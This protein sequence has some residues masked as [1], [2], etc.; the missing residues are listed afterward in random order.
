MNLLSKF[1]PRTSPTSIVTLAPGEVYILRN[2]KTPKGRHECIFPEAELTLAKTSQE[3]CYELVVRRINEEVTET[4]SL[5]GEEDD[6]RTF[7]VDE[8]IQIGYYG[9][10][11]RPIIS[12][13]DLSGDDGDRYEFVCSSSISVESLDTFYD[14]ASVAQYERKYRQVP[15]KNADFKEFE[16][17]YSSEANSS[18]NVEGSKSDSIKDSGKPAVQGIGSLDTVTNQDASRMPCSEG[19]VIASENAT[20]CLFDSTKEIFIPQFED[21]TAVVLDQGNYE[22]WL[23]FRNSTFACLGTSILDELNPYSHPGQRALIFNYVT[24]KGLMLSYLAQ[25][26][27]VESLNRFENGVAIAEWERINRRHWQDLGEVD[28]EYVTNAMNNATIEDNAESASDEEDSSAESEEDDVATSESLAFAQPIEGTAS[29]NARNSALEVGHTN[30][31]TYVVRGNRI[32]VFKQDDQNLQYQ[33]TIDNVRTF[34]GKE[35]D[36]ARVMLHERDRALVLQGNEKDKLYRM[37]LEYGKIVDEWK[38]GDRNVN[39]FAPISK[40]AQTTSEQ[41]LFGVSGQSMF[42]IDPRLSGSKVVGDNEKLYKSKMALNVLATT[43]S[44]YMVVGAETGDIRLYDKLGRVAKTHIPGLGRGFIGID[45]TADGRFVLATCKDYLLLVETAT[46][47]HNGFTKSWAKDSKPR[48]ILLRISPQNA[49]Y[50]RIQTGKPI[51]FTSARFNTGPSVKEEAII[52]STGPYLVIWNLRRVL[53]GES[54]AYLVKRYDSDITAENFKFGTDKRMIVALENDVSIVS[55][56][57]L[58]KPN[59]NNL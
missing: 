44:G 1:L 45:V 50:M 46:Q 29:L 13:L 31:R 20:L 47:E 28:Q 39:D 30:D 5:E 24:E 9:S 34:G 26:K 51:S 40:F 25:F 58:R 48:P 38:M 3:F 42:Q 53:R 10:K 49:S 21:V 37:D 22:Y 27:S 6:E 23:E 43:E 35:L 2:E 41:S 18:K 15:P 36:P 14:M 4:D 17:D 56:A 11:D 55:K 33:T 7:L 57:A 52:T 8:A 16:F 12:W 54:D 59:K 32:G 19:K